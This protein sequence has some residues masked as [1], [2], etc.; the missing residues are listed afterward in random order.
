[1]VAA[2]GLIMAVNSSIPQGPR[3]EIV[4]V[5]PWYSSGISFLA[6]ARVISSRDSTAICLRPF[7]PTFLT[8]G[9]INPSGIATASPTSTR[10]NL[11]IWSPANE[12]L[13]FGCSASASAATFISMSFTPI[14]IPESSSDWLSSARN[15]S[16]RLMSIWLVRKK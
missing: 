3:L 2:G 12:T 4:K 16:T 9:V 5:A 11:R 1:M 14:L 15:L 6:R 13:T 8:T 7:A 10:V